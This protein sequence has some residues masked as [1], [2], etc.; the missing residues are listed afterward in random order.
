MPMRLFSCPN[1]EVRYLPSARP[2]PNLPGCLA[3]KA[4]KKEISDRHSC[5]SLKTNKEGVYISSLVATVETPA[6]SRG[7]NLRAALKG[8]VSNR[9]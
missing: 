2:C 8:E 1:V 7:F 6:F 5:L 3:R 4:Q 9:S